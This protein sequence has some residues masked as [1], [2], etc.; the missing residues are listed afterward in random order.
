MRI[1]VTGASGLLGVNLAMEASKEHE[2]IGV[3][4][5]LDLQ[6]TPFRCITAELMD[7]DAFSEVLDQVQ[8]DW[9]IHCAALA[10]LDECEDDPAFAEMMNSELPG[11]VAKATRAE[12]AWF[13]F[14]P[15]RCLTAPRADI[16]KKTNLILRMCTAVQN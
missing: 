3:T 5:T 10:N 12:P 4:N 2:V 8:P 11:E 9:V 15:T 16:P 13:I 14:P 7:K 6:G 1:L